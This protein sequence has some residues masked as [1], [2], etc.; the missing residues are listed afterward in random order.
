MGGGGE[1]GRIPR[2]PPL[3]VTL[4][5]EIQ[6]GSGNLGGNTVKG[7]IHVLPPSPF[8]EPCFTK[9]KYQGQ[10]HLIM[11][12]GS[13]PLRGV[14]FSINPLTV[15]FFSSKFEYLLTSIVTYIHILYSFT[16]TFPTPCIPIS[17]GSKNSYCSLL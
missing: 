17:N 4:S 11:R 1:G 8:H 6:F 5:I 12:G 7:N 9:K 15:G 16:A 10:N 3:Y 2:A 14:L 13:F